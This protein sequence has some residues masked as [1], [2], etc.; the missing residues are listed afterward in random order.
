M[1]RVQEDRLGQ[2]D[3]AIESYNQALAFAPANLSALMGLERIAILRSD[4]DELLRAWRGLADATGDPRRK[5]AFLVDMIRL[6]S[7]RGD[8][9]D[10]RELLG[11]A[12]EIGVDTARI[13]RIRE[14]LA[15]RSG[16]PE[17]LLDALEARIAELMASVGPAGL[18]EATTDEEQEEL[19]AADALRLELV[20][21]RRRQARICRDDIADPER[22]W[23]YLQEAMALAPRESVLLADLADVAEQLGKFDELAELV[24]GWES[25]EADPARALSLSLRRA[26]ALLRAGQ[27]DRAQ[28]L[29]AGLSRSAP[30]YLPIQAMRERDAL[31]RADW[32]ILAS[33]LEASA[34][35][36]RLGTSY[37]PGVDPV[38]DPKGA[39]Y[40]YVAAGDVHAYYLGSDDAARTAYGQALEAVPGHPSAVE[41]M[42]TLH[43]RAGRMDEAASLLEL[44]SEAGDAA[45]R[46]YLLE[47]LL[48]IYQELGLT[49]DVLSTMKRIVEATS[50]SNTVDYQR[51]LRRLEE[52]LGEAGK[53]GERVEILTKLADKTEDPDRKAAVLLEAARATDEVLDDAGRAADLYRRVIELWP[54]D[55][56]ARAAL[57]RLLR[58]A[59]RWED[60]V[61]ERQA[62]AAQLTDAATIVRSLREAAHVLYTKLDRRD[63]AAA[64]YR[65]LRQRDPDDAFILQALAGALEPGEERIELL[66]AQVAA[67]EDPEGKRLALMRLATELERS[68]RDAD[69]VDVYRRAAVIDGPSSQAA[70]AMVEIS[71][72]SGNTEAVTDA[73]RE[74]ADRVSAQD[75]RASLTEEM[76]WLSAI[77]L[78]DVDRAA[79][80]F[81]E[82]AELDPGRRGAW[83]GAALVG[84]KRG[85]LGEV[86]DALAE[87]GGAVEGEYAAASL[88]LRSMVLA[89]VQGDEETAASRV[90]RAVAASP[91][92]AGTVVVAAEHLPPTA[93]AGASVEQAAAH[94]ARVAELYGLRAVLAGDQLARSD[95]ELDRAEALEGAGQLAA[96]ARVVAS[97]LGRQ[98]DNIRALQTLRRVAAR[99]GDMATLARTSVTLARIIGD[100]DGK[101]AFLREAAAILDGEL[102]DLG[103]AVHAYRR[104]L[105]V[106]P[107]APEFDRLLEI[108][109]SHE[110]L[111]PLYESVT[112]R[113]NYYDHEGQDKE[114]VPLLLTRARIRDRL[115]DVE[116]AARDYGKLL[117]IEDT[118]TDALFERAGVLVRIGEPREA[119][120]LY[121]RFLEHAVDQE[122]RGH[123]ELEL[124][125]I[126]AETM[127]DVAGAIESL[128]HVI[129]QT[130][131]DLAIRERLVSLLLRIEDYDRAIEEIRMLQEARGSTQEQAR[132][133]LRIVG[134]Y[135][136]Q[137]DA[138]KKALVALDRARQLDPLNV[139]AIRQLVELVGGDE[140]KKLEVLG[141]A[142]AD[143]RQ[144]IV[145]TPDKSSL[146][147]RLAVVGH[148]MEDHDARYF[149]LS[150]LAAIG[151]LTSDQK[152]FVTE[153]GAALRGN[154]IASSEP[155]SADE[156]HTL[157][158]HQFAAGFATELWQIIAGG[159]A[160]E[161]PQ[162][163]GQLG[164]SR[165]DRVK[166]KDLA[167]EFPNVAD[168][169]VALG[170][171]EHET[172]VSATKKGYARVVGTD[173]PVVFL[174][175]D[176][177]GAKGT[178]S[179]FLLGRALA[180]LRDRSGSLAD[181]RED[182][183]GLY[184]AAAAEVA[185]VSSP[186]VLDGVATRDK[187]SARAKTLAKH[188]GRKDKKNLALASSRFSELV[189]PALWRRALLATGNRA[190]LLVSGD[191]EATFDMLDLGVG[192]RTV[193][194]DPGALE[195]LAWA[196]S[197]QHM[198][199]RRKLG[200]SETG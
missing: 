14:R 135:R 38:P 143:V 31:E 1:A 128:D 60:L 164:F 45:H 80:L 123:A 149:S 181:L 57:I 107:G 154:A 81:F 68:N 97:V 127:H 133:E 52:L 27:T 26:D 42:T 96:A 178:K 85:E 33:V 72:R 20:S 147:E 75:V 70:A 138:P 101:A 58:R 172:Y 53:V 99:G 34:N 66:E 175:A 54:Q 50:D 29:L 170:V 118:Q 153:R 55:R 115:G 13:A 186:A 182:E 193:A 102:G 82:A 21:L 59:E 146:Y 166:Y 134:L 160:A 86:G 173:K 94:F 47:R 174:S 6:H 61:A 106:D 28:E 39:A 8:E 48:R 3:D 89:A 25:Q 87:L 158:S 17:E 19:S 46:R 187:I 65:E 62:E 168:V 171:P 10:A 162:E 103:G 98:P 179:R 169:G 112:E 116:G 108:L 114:Q 79:E 189:D 163:P 24:Q 121:D 15:L 76:G 113:I 122:R 43:E 188:L 49:D 130:P 93:P 77:L 7:E 71:L 132:D 126:L 125:Q 198:T 159:V 22:A 11:E 30:G 35:A 117:D 176:V 100:P 36:A 139:D 4:Q 78:A 37:G 155:L 69:A 40:D 95:W 161:L 192:G 109:V 104:L 18:P 184:F 120:G 51:V 131:D 64:L 156:W 148:W 63:E 74:L 5:V 83:L 141:G 90:D 144:A 91:E 124:S 110:D 129:R 12:T 67:T 177:A 56:Y 140:D 119:A 105:S 197:G 23:E 73:I 137:L 190:G 44:Q 167:R 2:I 136:E 151:S 200:L 194:D 142:A 157:L 88:L 16:D 145:E 41:A 150:A 92:D 195:L 9:Y 32:S 185:G 191:I 180:Q 84:A 152:K 183:V 111:G 196:V 165:G 199:L